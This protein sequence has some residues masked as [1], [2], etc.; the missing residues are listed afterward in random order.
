M[1]HL[2][3]IGNESSR[4]VALVEEPHLRCLVEV[5]SVY[6][7]A[8]RCLQGGRGLAEQSMALATGETLDY[9]TVYAGNS[10]WRL[11]APIDVP[12]SPARLTVAGT[13]LTHLGSAK[14][15]QA[16]HAA[17]A[18]KAGKA[19][20]E[21]AETMTDSMKMF[22]WGVEG[23][24]PREGEIG[25]A[26]EWFYKGNG[27]ILRGP[28][29]ALTV[30]PYAEDGGEEAEIA[31]VYIVGDDGTPCRLGMTLGNEF[32]DHRFEKRNYLNL[33]GS[34]LRTCSVGPELV[35]GAE[36]HAVAGEVRIQRGAETVWAKAIET[37]E[38]NMCHS[39]A[40]LEHHHFK[41]E[42]HR[43]PGD[44]HVHFFGAHSLSFGDHVELQDGDWMEVRYE[45]Y[46]RAL[47]NPIRIE[48]KDGNRFLSVRSLA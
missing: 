6:E 17:D 26:P 5:Q 33:A 2:V 19:T 14:D 8:Q 47:K 42:G 9:D 18:Q 10:E 4:R 48:R 15:R 46:G 39:L 24:R 45:G 34:K 29:E 38:A 13:G 23:G 1:I 44:V 37:G 20:Q 3:Q 30:P 35:V 36:F 41:F 11:L 32:S 7:L 31:G 22:Q 40:N 25:I 43:Q 21:V 27:S 16:M 28:F 12:G